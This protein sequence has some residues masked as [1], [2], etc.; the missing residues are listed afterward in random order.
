MP[1]INFNKLYK[2]NNT[3]I[4]SIWF[5]L[6]LF[7]KKKPIF[8]EVWGIYQARKKCQVLSLPSVCSYHSKNSNDRPVWQ[9][10]YSSRFYF[11]SRGEGRPTPKEWPQPHLSSLFYT[12]YLLLLE[13]A[14]CKTG[15]VPTVDEEGSVFFLTRGSHSSLQ[16]FLSSSFH[17]LFPFFVC[18][19]AA[20][21]AILNFFLYSNYLTHVSIIN[22]T[23]DLEWQ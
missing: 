22:S 16:N 6:I 2:F 9:L 23:M 8:K 17:G 5:R 4:I 21:T 12:F 10:G 20:A 14:L 11:S 13:P 15:L 18:L 1:L 7:Y 3:I 19:L